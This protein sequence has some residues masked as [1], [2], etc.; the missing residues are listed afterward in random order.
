MDS[1]VSMR[2]KEE[3]RIVLRRN[4]REVPSIPFIA[5]VLQDIWTSSKF[6]GT[7]CSIV[8]SSKVG[9]DLSQQKGSHRQF[10]V[11]IGVI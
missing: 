5:M 8:K 7:S 3:Y 1:V 11:V 6:E 4:A 2:R 9:K 10:S